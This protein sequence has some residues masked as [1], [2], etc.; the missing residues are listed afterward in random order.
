MTKMTYKQIAKAIEDGKNVVA[1]E[2]QNWGRTVVRKYS[3]IV[4]GERFEVSA[5][6]WNKMMHEHDFAI[7]DS[8]EVSS[9]NGTTRFVYSELR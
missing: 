1:R 2:Q 4:D 6:S 8:S 3:V 7:T 5:A 9:F